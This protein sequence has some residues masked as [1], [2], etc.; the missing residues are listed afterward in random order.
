MTF[1]VVG[2]NIPSAYQISNS[3]RFN[4]G[5]SPT[6]S[7]TPA[8]TGNRKTWTF[9]YWIKRSTISTVQQ[10]FAVGTN[11][12]TPWF[13]NYINSDDTLHV[14]FHDGTNSYFSYGLN[15]LRDV[16]AWYH[17]MYVVDTTQSTASDRLKVY[18]NGSEMT[19]NTYAPPAQNFDTQVNTTSTHYIGRAGNGQ[20]FDGYIAETYFIDGQALSPTDFGEFDEDSG[21]WKP[22]EYSGSYGTNGFYLDFENSGSLG[23]DQSGNGNDFTPTNLAST[24]QTTDTPTNNFATLN[25]LSDSGATLSEGNTQGINAP[26]SA[27]STIAPTSGKWYV[28]FQNSA[29]QNSS[30][31]L[32]NLD[33]WASTTDI[34]PF[35]QASAVLIESFAN[36]NVTYG[37]TASSPTTLQTGTQY[38]AS[39]YGFAF[40]LDNGNVYVSADGNWY[41]G[42]N[43]NQ[44]SFSNAVAVTTDI[45]TNTPMA[46]FTR[47][48]FVSAYYVNFGNPPPSYSISSGN[49]DDNGYGNFEYAPPSGYLALCTQNLA[50]ELSPTIDDGSQYFDTALHTGNNGSGR[51]FTGLNFQPDWIWGKVRDSSNYTPFS[52]DS[53]RGGDKFLTIS[54][55][56][57]EDSGSH[58]E[59][60]SFNSDGTTW[61]DGSNVTYPRLYYNDGSGS[62][63]GGSTYVFWQWK[64]N[65]GSTSSNTDGTITSTV[66]ANTTAG[67]SIVTYTG[68]GS[69]ATVGHGLGK[70]LDMIIVKNR[71]AGGRGWV[72]WNNALAGNE[73][74]EL[75]ATDAKITSAT[76]WNSTVPTSSVFSVGTRVGTNESS[77]TFV[78]YCFADIEG[79]SK[80]G[81]YTGN[82]STD[83]TFVYTGF[84]PAWVLYKKSSATENWHILDNK[85]DTLNP[86]SFGIDPNTT[87]AEANDANLQMDFLSNGFKLRTSHGTANASGSTYIYM[88]FAESPFVT[89][90]S[91]PVTA[92]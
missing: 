52:V 71:S 40:D 64:A 36:Y 81:K 38:N 73:A 39:K 51:T 4:D 89:S 55:S 70:A 68:T 26:S 2:S 19:W 27:T 88:A 44:A 8:S 56:A 15:Q 74:L 87:G 84:R 66:Q 29:L 92:R 75:N 35:A 48:S 9:S 21:I 72:V 90:T 14:W 65:G 46:F 85:R 25:P 31:G 7:R 57:T 41:G 16:S 69:N 5:D 18:I 79:Y 76:S 37:N 13:L 28:E 53:S 77:Q 82:G 67:F 86:N 6:L 59:V 61:I 10:T 3:L 1:P 42:S 50:T 62:A 80:F 11:A 32:V 83:G 58:G 63:L 17:I 91:I 43:F 24:D 45:P 54:S 49:S 33:A 30:I 12:A 47:G 23:A 20:Y 60:S 22:I 78:A 34:Y